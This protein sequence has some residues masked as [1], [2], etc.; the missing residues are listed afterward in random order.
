[1]TPTEAV[2]LCRSVKAICPAQA[3]DAYTPDAWH[4]VLDDI[5]LTDAQEAIRALGKIQHFIDPADIRAE[6]RHIRR[7]RLAEHG[8]PI[9]PEGLSVAEEIRW[10]RAARDRIASG[11]PEPGRGVHHQIDHDAKAAIG[12]RP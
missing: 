12:G 11:E 6:V 8:D 2:G 10:L 9:P 3:M 7:K 5:R 1:M 4:L